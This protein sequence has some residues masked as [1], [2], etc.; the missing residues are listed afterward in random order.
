MRLVNRAL[1]L[2][3]QCSAAVVQAKEEGPSAKMEDVCRIVVAAGYRLAWVGYGEMDAARTVTSV[4]HAGLTRISWIG[5]TSV[6]RI[7]SLGKE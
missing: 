2:L 5:Y 4:A 3:S 1:L 7:T 6:G